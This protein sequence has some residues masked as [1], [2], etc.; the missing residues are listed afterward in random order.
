MIEKFEKQES[1]NIIDLALQ[2]N[3]ECNQLI[4]EKT[5][6]E[7]I[8]KP[9]QELT[10][11]GTKVIEIGGRGSYIAK[12]SPNIANVP[13]ICWNSSDESI[14]SIDFNGVVT[15][16]SRGTVII[17]AES[18]KL[19]TS[20]EVKIVDPNDTKISVKSNNESWGKVKGS[21]KYMPGETI[22]IQAIEKDNTIFV[23]WNDGDTNFSRTIEVGL[24]N[25]E[26]IAEFRE[27]QNNEIFY[28]SKNKNVINPES[29][30]AFDKEIISNTYKN[31]KG[32]IV[33]D[34]AVT[35]IKGSAFFI[36]NNYLI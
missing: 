22:T 30:S 12:V 4:K 5:D 8:D 11:I 32:I 21:G 23:K 29:E 15:G 16:I 7:I 3:R 25:K 35:E 17:T 28:K 33:F 1:V 19:R 34:G 10:I 26:F 2:L 20:A 6:F 9:A 36:I 13:S 24:E 31:D 27:Q 18:G 14:A